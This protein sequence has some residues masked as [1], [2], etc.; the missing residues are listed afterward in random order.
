MIGLLEGRRSSRTIEP[1]SIR[2]VLNAIAFAT[3]PRFVL[4]DDAHNRTRSVSPSAGALHAV[5]VLII[6][7]RTFPRLL[8]YD[9][10][11]HHVETLRLAQPSG[12]L[13]FLT[14]SRELL[15]DARA[16][17]LMFVGDLRRVE[18]L[19][20]HPHSLLWRDAGALLQTLALVAAAY[21]LVFCPLGLLGGEI[22]DALV[23]D[24]DTALPLGCAAIGR[25]QSN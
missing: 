18:A 25:A 22:V 12:L 15:P 23:L 7:P 10:L 5:D 6:E 17:I 21:R 3:R 19:Y 24:R 2:E 8:R 11:N 13:T 20:E 14:M 9:P 1:A 4:G 16:T